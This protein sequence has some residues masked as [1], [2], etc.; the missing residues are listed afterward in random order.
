MNRK[1]A[2]MLEEMLSMNVETVNVDTL[3]TLLNLNKYSIYD[4][5][6]SINIFLKVA[7][8]TELTLKDSLIVIPKKEK[9][10][11]YAAVKQ[12]TYLL[13]L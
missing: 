7:Q 11:I 1:S 13:C 9:Q 5:L 6:K 3:A 12:D 4:Y 8:I 10:A 2:I